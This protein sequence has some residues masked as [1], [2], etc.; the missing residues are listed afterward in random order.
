MTISL[1]G[2]YAALLRDGERADGQPMLVAYGTGP[3]DGRGGPPAP[4]YLA[5]SASALPAHPCHS[6]LADAIG[7]HVRR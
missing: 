1:V 5:G 3:D 4:V 7:N 2:R 6:G